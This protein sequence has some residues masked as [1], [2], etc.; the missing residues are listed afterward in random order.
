MN[1][2]AFLFLVLCSSFVLA[3][4][5]DVSLQDESSV[6]HRLDASHFAEYM[7]SLLSED[8]MVQLEDQLDEPSS[9]L[10]TGAQVQD[11]D[12]CKQ[13]LTSWVGKCVFSV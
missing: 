13:I 4:A 9:F 8:E 11:A 7:R 3:F 6:M 12:S 1:F 5:S 2:F 10:E